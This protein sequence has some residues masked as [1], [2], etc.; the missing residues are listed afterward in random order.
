MVFVIAPDPGFTV[1]RDL[2]PVQSIV[3]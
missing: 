2:A 3:G 1:I